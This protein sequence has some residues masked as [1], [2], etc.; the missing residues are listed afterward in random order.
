VHRIGR[1]ARLGA[2]GDA[3]SLACETYAISLPDIE[4]YIGQSI[5]RGQIEPAWLVMP[6]PPPRDSLTVD[7]D[8]ADEEN[9]AEVAAIKARRSRSGGTGGGRSGDRGGPRSGTSERRPREGQGD[10]PPRE[11]RPRAEASSQPAGGDAPGIVDAG[12]QSADGHAVAPRSGHGAAG[13]NADPAPMNADGT[14]KKRRRRGGR[15]RNRTAEGSVDAAAGSAANTPAG[16][17]HGNPGRAAA[18]AAPRGR[19]EPRTGQRKTHEQAHKKESGLKSLI[20][21]VRSLFRR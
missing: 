2:E 8:D 18:D 1:T 11:R 15:N 13:A 5:P 19:H 6:T 7:P 20:S 14:P 4:T 9:K 10:R 16:Q 21:R 12:G 17:R 3:I